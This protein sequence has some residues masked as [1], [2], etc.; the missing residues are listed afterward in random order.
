MKFQM[1]H[2]TGYSGSDEVLYPLLSMDGVNYYLWSYDD[3]FHRYDGSTGWKTETYDYTNL[4]NYFGGPG[5]YYIGFYAVSAYGNNMFIDDINVMTFT[6]IPDGNPADNTMSKTFTLSYE[7]D[8]GIATITEPSYTPP[9]MGDV[10]FHQGYWSPDESWAFDTSGM[11]LG[12]LVYEDFW[13]LTDKIGDVAFWGLSLANTG[14]WVEASPALIFDII[15]Y[16][17]D[18]G[19]PGAVVTTF[20]G[21]EATY[22]DTGLDYIGF[23]MYKWSVTLPEAV[24]MTDGWISIQSEIPADSGNLMWATGPD[25]NLN[26]QQLQS[27]VLTPLNQNMAYDLGKAETGPETGNWPPGTYQVAGIV[28]NMGVTYDETNFDVNTQITNATGAIVYDETITVVDIIAP[29]GTLAV[30]FPDITIADEPSA[31]GT[32]KVTMK[33]ML[34]GDDHTNNDKKT[35]TFTIQR[36]DITPPITTATVSGTEGLDDWYVS[37]V[38]V[39]LTAIDPEGKWPMGVNHTYYKIDTGDY[40]E[41]TVPIVVDTDG[42]HTV[43]FYSDDKAYPANVEE[44]Q[45]VSFKRDATAPEFINYTFTP[46]NFMKNKWLCSATVE[47][48]T[49]GVTLVEFYVDDALVGNATAEPYEF[50]FNG[51]PTN[52]SQALAYDAAGNSALSAVAQYLELN[53]QQSTPT[54]QLLQVKNL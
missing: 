7:H 33:T 40:Q 6:V 52:S 24:E 54:L 27:G 44:E 45:S 14:G 20:T 17:D 32:Y 2:D 34:V 15:F 16:E 19:L 11:A 53:Q 41:Y 30:T 28:K 48:E 25:G 4:I 35:M 9:K 39:T 36:P 22:E 8:V 38:Q 37:D 10:I 43:Y 1:M 3:A 5:Y 49:S 50:T 31:E 13:G 23:S 42:Q 46:L 21:L 47:D 51:K 26:A 12:Y 18:A 29:Q